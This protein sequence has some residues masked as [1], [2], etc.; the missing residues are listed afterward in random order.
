M[1]RFLMAAILGTLCGATA[2]R[3]TDPIYANYGLVT[4]PPQIDATIFLNAGQFDFSSV[5]TSIGYGVSVPFDTQYTLFYTNRGFMSS[6]IGWRFDYVTDDERSPADWFV[7]EQR[8]IAQ[9]SATL[10]IGSKSSGFYGLSGSSFLSVSATNIISSGA[11][12]A[13]S[14]G[15]VKIEGRNIDLS[16]SGLS[17]SD[18]SL[19][20]AGYYSYSTLSSGIDGETNYLNPSD[21]ADLYWG[22]GVN[23]VIGGDGHALTVGGGQFGPTMASSPSFQ[24]IGSSGYTNTD[25]LPATYYSFSTN[26]AAADGIGTNY[27]TTN[28]YGTN[29]YFSRSPQ[30]A[31]FYTN[32]TSADNGW[33]QGV[34]VTSN[35]F[36]TNI[37]I[38]V[39]FLPQV[40]GT[41]GGSEVM[42]EFSC[43]DEDVVSGN[44]WTNYLYLVDTTMIETNSILKENYV[45]MAGRPS[46]FQITR[47]TPFDWFYASPSNTPYSQMLFDNPNYA[48]AVVTNSYSAYSIQL[49]DSSVLDNTENRSSLNFSYYGD[50]YNP[51]LTDP[52]NFSG[53]VELLG[54]DAEADPAS[55]QLNLRNARIRTDGL[56][57][58][59]TKNLVSTEGTRIDAPLITVDLGSTNQTLVVSNLFSKSVNRMK[60]TLSVY[61][62]LWTNQIS[63]ISVSNA[64]GSTETTVTTNLV[65]VRFH[66]MIVDHTLT[67]S[68]SVVAND[69]ALRATNIVV[70]DD[71]NVQRGLYVDGQNLTT[72]GS[73]TVQNAIGAT[74]LATV[75]NFTNNGSLMVPLLL[76]LG[77]DRST[78]YDSIV[79]HGTINA[80]GYQARAGTW[81]AD[82]TNTVSYGELYTGTNAVA[83]NLSYVS[84]Y[85]GAVMVNAGSMVINNAAV[86]AQTDVSLNSDDFYAANSLV[87]AGSTVTASAGATVSLAGVL[88][89]N[90]TNSIYDGGL[91]ASN[92][93]RVVGSLQMLTKPAHGD[94]LGTTIETIAP[95]L[96]VV[97][98]IWSGQ[99]MGLST[100]GFTN[101]GALGA[102]ILD[103]KVGSH[104]RFVGSGTN[105]ALYVDYLEFRNYATNFA[106]VL[107]VD[108][109]ITV[110]FANA[111][112]PVKKLDGKFNG[113]LRWINQYAGN[114]SGTDWVSP[115]TETTYRVNTALLNST[116]L[117]S[118]GDGVVNALDSTPFYYGENVGLNLAAGSSG[119][120]GVSIT[121]NALAN[122]TNCIDLLTNYTVF[123][124]VY[125]PS[126]AVDAHW[127][128][129]TN[130]A[131]DIVNTYYAYGTNEFTTNYSVVPN[132]HVYTNFVQGPLTESV[133]VQLPVE[134]ENLRLYRVRVVKP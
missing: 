14:G 51:A 134:T 16:N 129:T 9:D 76:A 99:D 100:A 49:G 33:V 66:V 98:H 53:R 75:M 58:I 102:M 8:I 26:S 70:A 114:F 85:S 7:N 109:S 128:V 61:S 1:K 29:I 125:S 40:V 123:E 48:S 27:V 117:D 89:I 52:T 113:H 56:F 96:S 127:E 55:D 22:I 79:N 87:S 11:M 15:L 31:F 12:A 60:G 116:E 10:T 133:T 131:N 69:I 119:S 4:T 130:A 74:N 19:S 43:R 105:K 32:Q 108:P 23:Q 68:Q 103:A 106:S 28:Y 111:N 34:Y 115:I 81:I 112:L 80:G 88:S 18:A 42:I 101:N 82:S 44:T 25:Y 107:D 45:S 124:G 122:A 35:A 20:A 37:N 62:A 13:G 64:P 39:R 93:W 57:T 71:I 120:K 121:W 59:K 21:V 30:M 73:F 90:A 95:K 91:A 41:N 54:L 36:D 86:V 83:T 110:Y 3:A 92:Y 84:A 2:A 118:D 72:E 97:K 24:V 63:S 6:P 126:N 50:Y 78:P 132:W 38:Q 65:D 94:L 67:G 104:I 47:S 77:S 17:A 5:S 46:G